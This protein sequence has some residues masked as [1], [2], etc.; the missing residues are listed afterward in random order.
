LYQNG[1][2]PL[3]EKHLILP[4]FTV[5]HAPPVNLVEKDKWVFQDFFTQT[6]PEFHYT[7]LSNARVYFKHISK[8]GQILKEYCSSHPV[9][10]RDR[11]LIPFKRVGYKKKKLEFALS[12]VT[13][14]GDNFHHFLAEVVPLIIYGQKIFGES[15]PMLIPAYYFKQPYIAPYLRLLQ[16]NWVTFE[17]REQVL[18]SDLIVFKNLSIALF[19]PQILDQIR[20]RL[21]PN[22]ASIPWRRVFISR[23]KARFRKVCDEEKLYHILKEKGFEILCLEDYAIEDQ[24]RIFSETKFLIGIHGAGLTNMVYMPKGGK[25]L[26]L[27]AITKETH[28]YNIFYVM[29]CACGQDYFYELGQ[30]TH[31]TNKLSDVNLDLDKFSIQLEKM[32]HTNV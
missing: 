21:A 13:L 14:F 2:I 24:I 6:I 16:V 4:S 18:V 17:S 8:H 20:F 9:P 15:V 28:I 10:L 22:P 29:A 7:R 1:S 25:V 26:E 19:N 3:S 23:A 27:R 31:P 12:L 11:L 30:G 5:N 32:L